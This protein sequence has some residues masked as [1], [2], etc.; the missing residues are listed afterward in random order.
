MHKYIWL[1]HTKLDF[2]NVDMHIRSDIT[3]RFI[4]CVYV[5][6]QQ[7]ILHLFGQNCL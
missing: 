6:S 5:T 4:H 2:N 7:K 1:Y 3:R